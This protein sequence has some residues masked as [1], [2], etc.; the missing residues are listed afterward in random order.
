VVE[1]ATRAIDTEGSRAEARE[2]MTDVGVRFA[3]TSA[4]A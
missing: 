1:E 2:A 4:V 3:S